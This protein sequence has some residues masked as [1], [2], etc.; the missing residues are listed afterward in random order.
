MV[1]NV[2]KLAQRLLQLRNHGRSAHYA[3]QESG[4]NSRMDAMQAAVLSQKLDHLAGWNNRRR[5]IAAQYRNA[6]GALPLLT[7]PKEVTGTHTY[8]QFCVT[9][10]HGM[11]DSLKA[12]LTEAGIGCNIFYPES[13]TE[14]AF[15]NKDVAFKNPCPVAE[16]VCKNILALPVWPELTAEEVES[17]CSAVGSFATT[18]A[19]QA[20]QPQASL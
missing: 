18:H 10:A 17:I 12:H 6:L 14:I 11:R 16:N 1:T 5:A 13:F 4:S 7:L 3:Y 15:L 19:T 8:H 2:P 20:A 9:V